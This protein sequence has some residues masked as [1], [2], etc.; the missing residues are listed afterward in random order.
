QDTGY[1]GT[2]LLRGDTMQTNFNESNS[3][4]QT[5]SGVTFNTTGLGLHLNRVYTQAE[6]RSTLNEIRQALNTLRTQAKVFGTSLTVIQNRLDYTRN[7]INYL[8]EGADQLTL[9]DKNQ[10]GASL[11]SLQTSQQ[12]GITALSLASQASQAVLRLFG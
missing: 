1:R 4:V 12:M 5:V 8:N 11:L 10:E 9:A 2:N 7:L 3:S 6:A